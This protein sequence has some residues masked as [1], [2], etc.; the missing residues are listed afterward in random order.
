VWRVFSGCKKLK[1]VTFLPADK[2]TTLNIG[3]EAFSGCPALKAV[4]LPQEC[5][6]IFIGD[7]A[8]QNCAALQTVKNTGC[9]AVLDRRVF[10]GCA[11][12]KSLTLPAG[13]QHGAYDTFRGS[14]LKELDIRG[15]NPKLF[16]GSHEIYWLMMEDRS[17]VIDE[18]IL[19]DLPKKCTVYVATK[20]MKYAVK[21]HGFPGT[22]R[23]RVDVPTPK[24]AKVTKQNGKVTLKWSKVTMA[25]GYRIWSYDAATGKYQKLATVKAPKTTVT[26][27]TSARQFVIRA[28]RIEAGDVSWSAIKAFT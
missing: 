14:S 26:L 8:F 16:D 7:H 20:D 25:D 4:V 11:S 1:K 28:Y 10:E 13:F 6:Q 2:K 21:S 19:T 22:V 12:L 23:I 5:G 18:N 27:K 9:L 3:Q 15:K 24:T 17:D